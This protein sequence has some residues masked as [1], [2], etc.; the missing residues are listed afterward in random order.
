MFADVLG[1]AGT[2]M[3]LGTYAALQAG[4]LDSG[5]VPYSALNGLGALLV[6]ISLWF[7]FNLAAF[8][9]ELAWCVISAYGVFRAV[10][11]P[12]PDPRP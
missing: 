5:R 3:I 2:V 6:L 11:N 1:M 10:T 4:K 7:E 12:V 9:L 8:V